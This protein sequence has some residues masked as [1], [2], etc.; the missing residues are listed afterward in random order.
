MSQDLPSPDNQTAYGNQNSR[1][2]TSKSNIKHVW[3]GH[4]SLDTLKGE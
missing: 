4:T 2:G 1:K 3:A